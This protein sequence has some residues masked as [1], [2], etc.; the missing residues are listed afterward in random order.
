ME[1]TEQRAAKMEAKNKPARFEQLLWMQQDFGTAKPSLKLSAFA[2]GK[3]NHLAIRRLEHRSGH[4]KEL[5]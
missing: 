3:A 2:A 1:A 4:L 5:N